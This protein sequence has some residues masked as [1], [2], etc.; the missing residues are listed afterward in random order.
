MIEYN[1][2]NGPEFVTIVD[3]ARWRANNQGDHEA[4]TFLVDGEDEKVFLNYQQFDRRARQV[5]AHL[6]QLGKKG[7]R[8]M[9]L[10]PPGM[11][12]I[13]AFYGC[14]YAGMTA[15]PLYPHLRKKKDKIFNRILNVAK[16]AQPI[17]LLSNE[18]ITASSSQHFEEVEEIKNIPWIAEEQIVL[19]PE[20]WSNPGL[21]PD[22]L[23]FLQYTS[24]STSL[25]KG[26]MVSHGNLLHNLGV[27]QKGFDV[28]KSDITLNWLPPYHDM[29]LIGGILSP[30]YC[31]IHGILMPPVYFLQ[32]PLRWLKAIA[33][34]K[35]TISGGP[36]FSYD[37]CIKKIKPEQRDAL[38]L[39]C[40][41]VAFCGA[42]PIN[43]ETLK[44]FAEYFAASSFRYQSFF[45]SYGLAE[46]TLMITAAE[47]TR[48]PV[49]RPFDK[50]Q[51]ER[52]SAVLADE[53]NPKSRN[54]ISVGQVGDGL[55]VII[56]NPETLEKCK[57]GEI[58][59]IW[60]KG[61]SVARGYWGKPEQSEAAFNAY[62]IDTKEGPFMRT[63]DLGFFL[64]EEV[65]ITGRIKELIIIDGSN[66][67]PQDIEWSVENAHDAIRP[68]GASAF[69]V[70]LDGRERLII[71]VE[72]DPR[73]ARDM[74]EA[75]ERQ[76]RRAI[77]SIVSAEHDLSV[78]DIA[79]VSR[80]PKTTSGKI[81]HHQCEKDYL[82]LIN[83][84]N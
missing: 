16:D 40:W 10:L 11:S 3:I 53:G 69:S 46:T 13:N 67:Y 48:G 50:S 71:M 63:G 37:F 64:D 1:V 34:F 47:R 55:E 77:K 75:Q 36:N 66:Y 32:R 14:L 73:F 72:L 33:K 19:P 18:T 42:E 7:D 17:A 74:D 20:S 57:D 78:H 6:Q 61:D 45:P 60:E 24:G 23:A 49:I 79:F 21:S 52:H 59:E 70:A 56:V 9:I 58:G 15:I 80:L 26:V 35:A 28:R 81:Q 2:L 62:T 12:F 5:A 65:Y 82:E 4:Y 30:M 83:K 31:G 44:K 22:D 43:P 41:E 84:S 54:L 38:D 25:P 68:H 27:I 29:G 8:I 76:V 51:L 39:S